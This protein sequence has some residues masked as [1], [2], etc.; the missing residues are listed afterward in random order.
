VRRSIYLVQPTYRAHTGD[1]LQGRSLHLH[2]CA[3]PALSAAIPRQWGRTACLEY[4]EDVDYDTAAHVVAITSMGYDVIHGCE[5]A[6]EFRRRGRVV[7]FGGYQAHFSRD[8]VRDVA[9]AVVYGHPGPREMARILDDVVAGCLQPEYETGTDINFPFDYS[10]LLGRRIAFM[11]VLTSVGC[12]NSCDFCCTAARHGGEY[13]L[14]RIGC[15]LA[16]L[17]VLRRHTDRFAV[18]DSNIYNNRGYLL[19]LCR[20]LEQAKLR[21]RWGAEATVDIAEDDEVLHA[22]RR[23]GCRMLYIGFE[24][25]LQDSLD[26]VNKP[27]QTA[28][29]DRAVERLR[30]H[31]F[32][33]AGYS[34]VGLDADTGRTFDELLDFIRR[35]GIN[36]PVI[37]IPLPV[38]GTAL[39]Q[40][41]AREDRLLVGTEDGFLRNALFYASSCSHCFYRPARLTEDE[42]EQGLLAVR[43]RLSTLRE[44]VRRSLVRDPATAAFLLAANFQFR[45]DARRMANAWARNGAAAG[46][47]LPT[48]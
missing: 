9:D 28:G 44:T 8:R 33:V 5:I 16:D 22:L 11:P 38:P 20:A 29:Y 6:A 18:V 35:T 10:M 47:T 17:H 21:M 12:R 31:G 15:V 41:L 48:T 36:L 42:L 37:N 34:L 2:S 25:P 23:A 27:Y 40:R 19:A 1:L 26:S 14:R 24:T 3:L 45:R 30:R 4:F 43:Q 7:I 46:V 13:R 39:F 32:V